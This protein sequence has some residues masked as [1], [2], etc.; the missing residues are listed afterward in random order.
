MRQ[1]PALIQQVQQGHIGDDAFPASTGCSSGLLASSGHGL[2]GIV[3]SYKYICGLSDYFSKWQTKVPLNTKSAYEVANALIGVICNYGCFEKNNYKSREGV[4]N[5]IIFL[6]LGCVLSAGF[7]WKRETSRSNAEDVLNGITCTV[8][9]W[10]RK[11]K[12]GCDGN[13]ANS[14]FTVCARLFRFNYHLTVSNQY[15][16]NVIWLTQITVK[17]ADVFSTYFRNGHKLYFSCL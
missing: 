14:N 1:V 2:R 9:G 17:P 15:G 4:Q 10:E 5:A 3:A 7:F 6:I 13:V 12:S 8:S 11:M 16:K